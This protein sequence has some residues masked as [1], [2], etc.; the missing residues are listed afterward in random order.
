MI[1]LASSKPRQHIHACVAYLGGLSQARLG[2]IVW[3]HLYRQEITFGCGCLRCM[4]TE[5]SKEVALQ[6]CLNLS[7]PLQRSANS[8]RGN[9]WVDA[10]E[11]ELVITTKYV[12]ALWVSLYL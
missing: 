4:D 10:K 8:W 6:G 11:K 12:A 5:G 1:G 7:C 3:P 2:G 9:P